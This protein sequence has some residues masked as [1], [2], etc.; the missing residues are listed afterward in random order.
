[1]FRMMFKTILFCLCMTACTDNDSEYSVIPPEQ[2]SG[3]PQDYT[4]LM[5]KT[6]AVPAEYEQEAEHRG[7]VVRIDYDTRDYAEG[8][9]AARTNT[10]YIY[11]PYG[12]DEASDQLYNVLYFVHGH[13]GTAAS[14]FQDENELLRKLLDHMTENGDMAPTIVVSPS[15]IYGE[16]TAYYADAD[17]YCKALPQELVNDLIPVI[18]SRY[19]TYAES[20]DMTGIEASREHRAI[21]GFS[22]GAVTTWYTLIVGHWGVLQE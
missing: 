3:V 17:P 2:E 8:T 20:T 6:V 14:F 22:M 1:M 7:S 10:A 13:E 9:G 15:Y 4:E 18:E 5:N 16:P 19:R 12:Y 21:G 11:L